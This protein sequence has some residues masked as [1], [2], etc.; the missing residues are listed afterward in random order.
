MFANDGFLDSNVH[1]VLFTPSY[2]YNHKHTIIINV[3]LISL[4]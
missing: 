1:V 2:M 3:I 4:A